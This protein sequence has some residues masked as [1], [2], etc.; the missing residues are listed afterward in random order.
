VGIAVEAARAVGYRSAGTI[1][2]LLSQDAEY[3]FL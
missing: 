1:E 2:G 3:F